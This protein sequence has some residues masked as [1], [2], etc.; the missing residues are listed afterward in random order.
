M[1]VLTVG[2]ILVGIVALAIAAC[3]ARRRPTEPSAVPQSL[4]GMESLLALAGEMLCLHDAEGVVVQ[5]TGAVEEIVGVSAKDIV[6]LRL[7]DFAHLDD[8]L[9][10]LAMWTSLSGGEAAPM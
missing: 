6:G 10:V 8:R 4:A 1:P 2:I 7:D 9:A 3:R 5:A